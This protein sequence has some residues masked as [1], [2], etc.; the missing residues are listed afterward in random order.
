MPMGFA[1]HNRRRKEMANVHGSPWNRGRLGP[2]RA[3]LAEAIA[4]AMAP[5]VAVAAAIDY[6]SGR[7]GIGFLIYRNR[8]V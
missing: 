6:R 8:D 5:Q 4:V 1:M 7:Q 2:S 3:S